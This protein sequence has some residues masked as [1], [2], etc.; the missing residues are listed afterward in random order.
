MN[1]GDCRIQQIPRAAPVAQPKPPSPFLTFLP[2]L[3]RTICVSKHVQAWGF[4]CPEA[5][6]EIRSNAWYIEQY[7]RR[8]GAGATQ[9]QTTPALGQSCILGKVLESLHPVHAGSSTMPS[10][11]QITKENSSNVSGMA[12]ASLSCKLVAEEI[13]DRH[14]QANSPWSCLL[15]AHCWRDSGSRGFTAP[16]ACQIFFFFSRQKSS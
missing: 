10:H 9:L 16:R 11:H 2:K 12:I 13:G 14:V 3:P 6:P 15:I 1:S 4:F 7:L 8:S 5:S